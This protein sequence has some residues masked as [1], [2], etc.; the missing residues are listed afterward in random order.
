MDLLRM[1]IT[2]EEPEVTAQ[3]RSEWCRSVA[4]GLHW[5]NA[6]PLGCGLNQGQSQGRGSFSVSFLS[7]V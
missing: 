3:N 2:W 5:P 7:G 4:T 6:W 1:G